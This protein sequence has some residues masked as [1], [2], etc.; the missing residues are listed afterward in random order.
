MEHMKSIQKSLELKDIV[1]MKKAI[2]AVIIKDGLILAISRRNDK[3]KFGFVGGKVDANETLEQALIR[4][5]KEECGITILQHDFFFLRQE[6]K[7]N[8]NG[9]DFDCY[10]YYAVTWEGEPVT[11]EEG[12]VVWKTQNELI[13]P[14]TSAFPEYNKRSLTVFKKKFPQV[15]LK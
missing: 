10:C 2:V 7:D 3:T 14:E 5:T 6:P 8:P 13:N 11:C 1:S 4:E 15:Y 12:D 9:E